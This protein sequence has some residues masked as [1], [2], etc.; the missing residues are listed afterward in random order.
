MSTR[1]QTQTKTT[2]KP[3]F[4]PVQTG[5]LQRKCA[6]GNSASLTGK[7]IE[8]ENKRLSLQRRANHQAEP[9]EVPPIVHEVLR[10]PG[11][12][13]DQDARAFMESR[14]GH[15]FSRVRLHTDGKAA[16]SARA[17]NA[18]AYTVGHNIVLGTEAH[19]LGS[20]QRSH[21]LAHELTHVVQ[22]S[23]SGYGVQ[24]Q[25]QIGAAREP[26]ESEADRVADIVVGNHPL[27]EPIPIRG[28][29]AG[30][31]LRRQE[32]NPQ[33]LPQRRGD[34]ARL[35]TLDQ[36]SRGQDQVRIHVFRYLCNC[37]GRNVRRSSFRGRIQPNP[38]ITYEFCDGRLTARIVG[39][40]IPNSFSTGTVRVG[41]IL[42]IAPEG[43]SAGVRIE[44][45]GEAR[46][47]GSEPQ[48]G[49]QGGVGVRI[50]GGPDIGARGG[51]MVGTQSGQVDSTLRGEVRIP[52]G[53]TIFVEGT[54]IQDEGRR[55]VTFGLGGTFGGPNV[56]EQICRECTC[57]VAYQ[58]MEDIPPREYTE[59][60]PYTVTDRNRLRYYFRLNTDQD[61]RN[62]ELRRES[63]QA[64]D[65]VVALVR[66]GWTVSA[67]NGFASPE[68]DERAL[69]EPLS[70]SRARRLHQLVQ[71]RLGSTT[72]LPQPAGRGEL[73]GRRPSITPGSGLG[74][75]LF[76]AGFSSPEEV[77]DFLF[78]DEIANDQLAAQF[79]ALLN[80]VTAREDRLRL[81][82]VTSSS[83]I[84]AQ[85]LTAIDQFIAGG[86]RGHR[87]W[88]RIF[89]F[90]RFA[91][92]EM[93]RTR[94]E[95]RTEERRTRGSI[96]EVGE[97]LCNGY[98][99]QAERRNLF[100]PAEREPGATECPTR[101]P[102]NLETYADRCNYD[103]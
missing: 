42:N 59:D 82:G 96:R 100:G 88:E 79:L 3:S 45:Q 53:P 26:A 84:A 21:L 75:A 14:F 86:G 89:E 16:E 87:P 64:F 43:S 25:L 78:G 27:S 37:R 8:C 66:D 39:D 30:L 4:T 41:G 69:N 17:V 19:C 36:P 51:A 62:P 103:R 35:A 65:Q 94:Q 72:T 48:V 9:D 77:T 18:L 68:A 1:S 95:I 34:D 40:I 93:T 22:Q 76:D 5:I 11:Q 50:P 90:L 60:V 28:E 52:G 46:N 38:G 102:G 6:C 13:L 20:R 101:D 98:A 70:D 81:F 54:N 7:C 97:A 55:G 92:V 47:T 33:T 67:I 71:S 99:Q 29:P 57:P 23:Q 49:G 80:R 2:P 56:E 83:P 10:S 32:A 44:A 91:S 74:D 58:C 12:P 24:R 31:R 15:D 73:L 63:I 61:T 85:L